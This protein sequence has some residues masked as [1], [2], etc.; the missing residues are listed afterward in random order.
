MQGR[1]G[2]GLAA[3]PT[4]RRGS[5]REYPK[6]PFDGG[7]LVSGEL[8]LSRGLVSRAFASGPFESGGFVSD[9]FESGAF[10]LAGFESGG[11]MSGAFVSGG[12]VQDPCQAFFSWRQP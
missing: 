8:C 5:F 9:A 11:F 3:M 6:V 12:S 7:A 10:V 1:K 4:A 2:V